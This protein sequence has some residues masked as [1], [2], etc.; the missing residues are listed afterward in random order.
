[1]EEM[2][3]QLGNLHTKFYPPKNDEL[4][5]AGIGILT[6]SIPGENRADVAMVIPN[7]AADKAGILPRDRILAVDGKEPPI[8]PKEL[9]SL[10]RGKVGTKVV[11]TIQTPGNALRQVEVTRGYI[12]QAFP[13]P[14]EDWITPKNN[15]VGYLFLGSFFYGSLNDQIANAITKMTLERPLD[16]LILDVRLNP[17]GEE[18]TLY[19]ALSFFTHGT[20]GYFVTRDEKSPIEIPNR[21]VN[22]SGGIPLVIL[23]TSSTSSA[24]GIFAGLLHDI[25]RAYLIGETTDKNLDASL[26]HTFADGSKLTIAF[27]AIHPINHPEINW[28]GTGVAPDLVVKPDWG[29]FMS[30]NDP[31]IRAALYYFDR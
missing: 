12:S 2:V 28:V 19:N 30:E 9:L 27:A 4:N 11:L 16:G 17:G 29:E 31:V 20:I 23:I 25:G 5:P 6:I 14:Y 10:L 24:G 18:S 15:H 1:M 13:V 21:E 3:A 7:S 8:D 22:G 26:L